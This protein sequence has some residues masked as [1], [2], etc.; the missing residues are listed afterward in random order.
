MSTFQK[1]G[2]HHGS[3]GGGVYFEHQF[4]H[5]LREA[6]E[7]CK[8]VLATTRNPKVPVDVDHTYSDKFVLA[9]WCVKAAIASQFALLEK[10]GLN[11]EKLDKVLEWHRSGR[12]VSLYA[13]FKCDVIFKGKFE[14]QVPGKKKVDY[15]FTV[16]KV[17]NTETEYVWSSETSWAI[18]LA[19]GAGDKDGDEKVIL[20][21]GQGCAYSKTL[22]ETPPLASDSTLVD[23]RVDWLLKHLNKGSSDQVATIDFEID[24]TN[25]ECRTPTRN[26]EVSEAF[27][28]FDR[29]GHFAVVS[30][31]AFNSLLKVS[32]ISLHKYEIDDR[33]FS[34]VLAM[35]A[36]EQDEEGNNVGGPYIASNDLGVFI[37]EMVQGIDTRSSNFEQKV[38]SASALSNESSNA[39]SPSAPVD[40][41]TCVG[42]N[43][44]KVAAIAWEMREI[45]LDANR[46]LN[47][48]ESMLGSQLIEAIGKRLSPEDFSKY[49]VYH[50]RLLFQEDY[51][52][53]PFCHAIRRPGYSPEG[54]IDLQ[55]EQGTNTALE[56]TVRH[57]EAQRPM[58]FSLSSSATVSFLGER[59]VHAAVLHKFSDSPHTQ[60]Q[61]VAN[62]RQ[63]SSFVLL[64]GS[65]A[66][67]DAFTPSAALIIK[68]QDELRMALDVTTVPTAKEFKDAISSLSPEQQDFCKAYRGLQLSSTLFGVLVIQIKPQMEMVLNLPADALTKEIQ[69]T[70]DLMELFITQQI[71]ADLMSYNGDPAASVQD[72]LSFVKSHV[73]S[74]QAM[75]KA[76]KDA[77]LEEQKAV[78]QKAVWNRQEESDG[79]ESGADEEVVNSN[80]RSRSRK[81]TRGGGLGGGGMMFGARK[82][83]YKTAGA[84]PP[85]PVPMAMAMAAQCSPASFGAPPAAAMDT[86]TLEAGSVYTNQQVL[87]EPQSKFE[88]GKGDQI[89]IDDD[90][91]ESGL[92]DYTKFPKLLDQRSELLDTDSALRPTIIK[93]SDRWV[94]IEKQGLLSRQ[95]TRVLDP[96]G[97]ETEKRRAFDLLDALTRSGALPCD[98]SELHVISA[99]THNFDQTLFNVLLQ[100][101]VNPIAKVE[102]S[103]L[104]VATTLHSLPVSQIVVPSRLPELKRTCPPQLLNG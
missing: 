7:A 33:T 89:E 98:H 50:N 11:G 75:I 86:F 34:P 35:F 62:A 9:K 74:I 73:A 90:G 27:E 93:P 14:T 56:T 13:S 21:Q 82:M 44:I 99:S 54:T 30:Q 97:Q 95:T 39:A 47:H 20:R 12:S 85:P 58:H 18:W 53:K 37:N 101:N 43:E 24:R 67:A 61:L 59:F 87:S 64:V 23:V 46:C 102:R 22:V 77:E 17:I 65:I 31:N 45:L 28:N 66:S 96:S 60:L 25:D 32:D 92:E 69:L 94:K 36:F 8:K 48:I 84:P 4:E 80:A 16:T 88:N 55:F 40:R 29:L 91:D 1:F 2:E 100:E 49:M 76:A 78:A 3:R 10:V 41:Q 81:S 42:R 38:S 71:P 63:F 104:I 52:P 83:A 19:P 15:G 79:S 5:Q 70:Q 26:P 51:R 72:K 103:S 57:A 6:L 68:N